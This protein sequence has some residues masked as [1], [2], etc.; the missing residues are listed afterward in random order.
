[1][2]LFIFVY[3]MAYEFRGIAQLQQ[4]LRAGKV[5]CTGLVKEALSAIEASAGLNAVL[6]AFPSGALSQAELVDKKIEAGKAGRLAGV[7]VG[8]KD[9]IC[10]RGHKVSASSRILE[11]FESLY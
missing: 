3:A 4:D 8:L 7:I 11:G 1:M 9:N 5:S 6:E 2:T 10:Y